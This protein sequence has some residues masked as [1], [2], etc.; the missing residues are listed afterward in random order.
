MTLT[1]IFPPIS[2]ETRNPDVTATL[3]YILEHLHVSNALAPKCAFCY[4]HK[5]VYYGLKSDLYFH[6]NLQ[7]LGRCPVDRRRREWYLRINL[8]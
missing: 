3:R 4:M 5:W 7:I 2:P 6:Y 8:V 1:L